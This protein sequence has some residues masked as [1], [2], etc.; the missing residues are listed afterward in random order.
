LHNATGIVDPFRRSSNKH[1]H[2]APLVSSMQAATLLAHLCVVDAERRRRAANPALNEKV[3]AL[4]I[5]QQRR[6]ALTYADLLASDRYGAATRYFLAELYGPID[7]TSRD[8][9]FAAVAPTVAQLFPG[10]HRGDGRDLV[11]TARAV[12]DARQ[13][14]GTRARIGLHHARR[15][16][17]GLATSRT[18]AGPRAP[19]RADPRDRRTPRPVHAPAAVSHRS[20]PDARTGARGRAC[21]ICSSCS[22]RASTRSVRCRVPTSSSSGSARVS[23]RSRRRCLRPIPKRPAALAEPIVRWPGCRRPEIAERTI[24]RR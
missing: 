19:G 1:T 18:P 12:R 4:K 6:F 14:D 13:R 5:Y 17:P 16:H 22:K 21:P 10:R 9:Q 11:G 2:S 24:R 7:F 15:L 20:A 8:A 3:G 23:A